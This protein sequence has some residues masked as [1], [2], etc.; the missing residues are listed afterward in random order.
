MHARR[1]LEY[2]QREFHSKY[3]C[4]SRLA[5]RLLDLNHLVLPITILQ[6][7]T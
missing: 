4:S 1:R 6:Q 3:A 2:K 5:G 7:S